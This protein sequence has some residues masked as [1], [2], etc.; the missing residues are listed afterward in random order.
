MELPPWPGSGGL[1]GF[2]GIP[3]DSSVD[4]ALAVGG[5]RLVRPAACPGLAAILT[6][7]LSLSLSF[8]LYFLD[9][10]HYV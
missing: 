2:L 6:G 8:P 4:E 7:F 1:G 5:A 9:L 10:L 3:R